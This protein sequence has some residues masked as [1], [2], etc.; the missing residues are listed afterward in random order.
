MGSGSFEPNW[1]AKTTGEPILAGNCIS[2]GSRGSVFAKASTGQAL[3]PPKQPTTRHGMDAPIRIVCLRKVLGQARF[4][5]KAAE[6]R[7]TPGRWRESCRRPTAR[8]VLDRGPW[9]FREAMQSW[10]GLEIISGQMLQG[11]VARNP[12]LNDGI[13]VG[14]GSANHQILFDVVLNNSQRGEICRR[15]RFRRLGSKLAGFLIR[16]I[17]GFLDF[18]SKTM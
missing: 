5:R 1:W 2:P 13:P 6:G 17:F 16:H 9:R 18:T 11:G 4:P 7:R 10:L 15:F 12:G 3:A 8:S 14:F